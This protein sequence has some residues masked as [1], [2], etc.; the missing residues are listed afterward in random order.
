M[1]IM[2][3]KGEIQTNYL[4]ATN[5]MPARKFLNDHPTGNTPANFDLVSDYQ[6]AEINLRP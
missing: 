5:K 1:D 4:L 3:D 2:A 6:P